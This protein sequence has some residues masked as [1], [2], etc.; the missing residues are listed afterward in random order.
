MTIIGK[1][2]GELIVGKMILAAAEKADEQ[3]KNKTTK[4]LLAT[5]FVVAPGTVLMSA[6]EMDTTTTEDAA[7]GESG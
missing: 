2:I 6:G 5:A 1:I 7:G 4:A 3:G